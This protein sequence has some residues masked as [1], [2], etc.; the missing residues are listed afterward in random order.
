MTSSEPSAPPL[1]VI[2]VTATVSP[3]TSSRY[4]AYVRALKSVSPPAPMGTIML[5]DLVGQSVPPSSVDEES[6][7]VSAPPLQPAKSVHIIAVAES[8]ANNFFQF[9]ILRLPF[10]S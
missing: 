2:L 10:F 4:I 1:P 7:V 5:M 8:R 6:S 9:F 3:N